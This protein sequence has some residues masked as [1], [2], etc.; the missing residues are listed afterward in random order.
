MI[1]DFRRAFA[2]A[3]SCD[4]ASPLSLIF[5]LLRMQLSSLAIDA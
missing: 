4:I 5:M 1:I 2:S 3:F